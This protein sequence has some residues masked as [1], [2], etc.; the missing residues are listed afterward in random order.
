MSTAPNPKPSPEPNPGS[1]SPKDKP[2]IVS[3]TEKAVSA[4]PKELHVEQIHELASIVDRTETHIIGYGMPV[5]F[6]NRGYGSD[7][8]GFPN[9]SFSDAF[10]ARKVISE[11]EVALLAQVI[12]IDLTAT[13]IVSARYD[14][15]GDGN[16]KVI[17]GIEVESFA[18]LPEELPENIVTLTVP[19]CRYAK[20]LINERKQESRIGYEERMKADEYFINAFRQDT[21]Y[22]YNKRSYPMNT[23]DPTGDILTKYE[24]V[25]IPADDA[26]RFDTMKFKVVTLPELKIACC[27]T[28]PD[29]E[30]F[31]IF[32]YF[33]VEQQV[34]KCASASYYLHDYYG[35]PTNAGEGKINS[36]FGTRVSTFDDLPDCVEKITVPGGLYVHITQLEFNGDDP[37]MPYDI[38]F[39]HLDSLF[40]ATHPSYER[41]WSRHVVARFRQANCASVF[42]PL[43]RKKL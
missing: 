37:S 36:C 32:K 12:G 35:F 43:N 39:N 33:E 17:V 41:D 42:V 8:Y 2:M 15:E 21:P 11:G 6:E 18:N 3:M 28:P 16:Y 22:V 5:S 38:A 23:Y 14:V 20:M 7:H 24:P 40:L 29:S 9:G 19:A 13:E 25:K 31:V 1:Y 26:E 10:F 30:D 4:L 27:V 34:Y